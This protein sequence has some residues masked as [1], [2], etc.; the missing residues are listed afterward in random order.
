MST[1]QSS[2]FCPDSSI[3]EGSRRPLGGFSEPG[4]SSLCRVRA[5]LPVF[6][7]ASPSETAEK[8]LEKPCRSDCGAMTEV[9][10]KRA[11]RAIRT[12]DKRQGLIHPWHC[13]NT[14]SLT[15]CYHGDTIQVPC[16]RWRTC[17]GCGRRKQ[18]QLKERFLAGIKDSPAGKRAMFFTLTFPADSAPTEAEA[19][20]AFRSLNRRLRY[21]DLL[22]AYG[23]VLQRQNNATQTLH[24][25]GIA[26]M[27][28][29]RDGLKEWRSLIKKSG[30]GVQNKLLVAQ[31][32]HAGYCS[33]YIST[34]LAELVP[35]R[36]AFSFSKEFPLS[37][38]E[39]NRREEKQH[40]ADLNATP[41]C[42]WIPAGLMRALT[43]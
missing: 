17:P 5:R 1:P 14:L 11:Q 41:I 4:N 12:S 31:P 9:S 18:F 29:M 38:W 20:A 27:P 40:W 15:C 19:Q 21:R 23:W 6:R 24:F 22:G 10:L 16:G 42:E 39:Q 33:R 30:F 32:S 34:N 2:R 36:R 25:H 28:W 37:E 13:N 43:Q 35:L 7:A 8:T 26:H 3:G